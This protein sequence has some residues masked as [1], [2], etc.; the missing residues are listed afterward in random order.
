[1]ADWDQRLFLEL[2][3]G[4]HDLTD[5]ARFLESTLRLLNEFG[6]AWFLLVVV[7][8]IVA[9][10]R[11]WRRALRRCLELGAAATVGGLGANRLKLVFERPRPYFG[12]S[13]AFA[14]GRATAA[15]GEQY[16]NFSFPSGHSAL[17]FSMAAILVWWTSTIPEA[18]RRRLVRALVLVAASLTALARVYAGSHYPADALA[19][20]GVGLLAGG[21]VSAVS[22]RCFGPFEPPPWAPRVEEAR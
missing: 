15:F 6:N 7:I 2:N 22:R 3:R 10:E 1:M 16:R 19:G 17:V 4:L 18:W 5:R 21:L 14:D 13:E 20:A 12:L 9:V 11:H 8:V